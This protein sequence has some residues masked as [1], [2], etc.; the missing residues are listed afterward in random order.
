[1]KQRIPIARALAIQPQVLILD[2]FFGALDA[3]TKE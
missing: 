2:E 1:M 3:I